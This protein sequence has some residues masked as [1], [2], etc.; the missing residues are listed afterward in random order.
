M[1]DTSCRPFSCEHNA[2]SES[3]SLFQVFFVNVVC[4]VKSLPMPGEPALWHGP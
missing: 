2:A 4:V 3:S 1:G